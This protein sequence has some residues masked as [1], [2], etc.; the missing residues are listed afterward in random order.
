MANNKHLSLE[1]RIRIAQY[2]E[3]HM[4]FR[5]IAHELDKDPTTISKEIRNHFVFKKTGSYGRPHN[6]CIHRLSCDKRFVCSVCPSVKTHT[7]CRFCKNCNSTCPDFIQ[8]F[9]PQHKK[10]PY[11]CNGCSLLKNCSLEKHFYDPASADTEYRES[12][13][14]AH[15]ALSLSEAEI[16]HLDSLVSPLIRK[17]Q[18]LHHICCNN[19]DSILISERTL[20]RLVDYNCFSA[21]NIDLPRKVRYRTRKTKRTYKVDKTCR[22]GRCYNDFKSFMKEHPDLP[23]T[24]MDSVEGNKGG[25]VLLTIHFVKAE[26]MLAFIREV[27]DSQSVI[28]IFNRLYLEIR[29]DIFMTIMPVLLGDNG[30]EFSNPKALEYDSQKN[31][32]TRVFYCDP[33]APYQ[34]GSAER[35][36]E[37]IRCFISKG[38]SFDRYSQEDISLMMDH[39]NSYC[40]ESLGNKCP[41]DM[42]A[43]LYGENV[44]KSLGCHKIAA[45]D[46]TLNKSIWEK[47]IP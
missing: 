23:I 25:K 27:N 35:N 37:L 43:F 7:Y 29:P 44:L 40:R 38:E 30:T 31:L 9:C 8:E 42:F 20:Y 6:S 28:D 45:N 10:P 32:R 2:L 3:Q 12:I 26:L 39:I 11:V 5:A 22:V 1:E 14:E 21:R 47:D 15:A 36:H 41:Y 17:G 18:S 16:H 46:V 4:S 19:K 34:K 13:S 24:Q 33:S